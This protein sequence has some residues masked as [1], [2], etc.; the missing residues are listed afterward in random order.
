MDTQVKFGFYASQQSPAGTHDLIIVTDGKIIGVIG[1]ALYGIPYGSFKAQHDSYN[2]CDEKNVF[3]V[4]ANG[5]GI[6]GDCEAIVA[7]VGDEQGGVWLRHI[8]TSP[9]R[10]SGDVIIDIIKHLNHCRQSNN[11][12]LLKKS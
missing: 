9:I 5:D 8:A 2:Y 7:F 6:D 3:A 12:R 10:S 11:I 4:A 1:E